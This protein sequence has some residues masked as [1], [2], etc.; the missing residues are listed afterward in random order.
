MRSKNFT[1][2]GQTEN[3]WNP[4]PPGTIKCIAAQSVDAQR[5]W[6]MFRSA[7]TVA[8]A[9]G[10]FVLLDYLSTDVGN[11]PNQEDL[12]Q[13]LSCRKAR[14]NLDKY[15]ADQLDESLALR[16]TEHLKICKSC[17][18]FRLAKLATE[19]RVLSTEY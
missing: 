11:I 6:F 14:E 18:T 19:Y 2:I 10:G 16:L 13:G 5:R 9:G 7:A 3:G 17:E 1:R 12:N 8:V 15:I 4:C